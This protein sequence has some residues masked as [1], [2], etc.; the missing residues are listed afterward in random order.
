[1]PPNLVCSKQGRHGVFG[2]RTICRLQGERAASTQEV[3]GETAEGHP[4]AGHPAG[5]TR[6]LGQAS[7][8]SVTL[9]H[10]DG[11]TIWGSIFI[12][13]VL[14]FSSFAFFNTIK[15]SIGPRYRHVKT[16]T[17]QVVLLQKRRCQAS[18]KLCKKTF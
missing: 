7:G 12:V 4:R 13:A 3:G 2:A 16:H 1:M 5:R 6:S 14:F 10:M 8:F 15:I 18:P 17:P 9:I 11:H